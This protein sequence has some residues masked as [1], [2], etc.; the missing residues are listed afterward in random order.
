MFG[1]ISTNEFLRLLNSTAPTPGGGAVVAIN[2]AHAAGLISMVS[3][4]TTK[5]NLSTQSDTVNRDL[6]KC[7]LVAVMHQ[8]KLMKAADADAA[9]FNSLMDCYKLP[10]NTDEE[11]AARSAA[12]I[13]GLKNA[14]EP[15]KQTILSCMALVDFAKIS[16]EQGDKSVV[17]DAFIACRLLATAIRCSVYNLEINMR[18]LSGKDDA[19]VEKTHAFIEK[20]RAAATDLERFIDEKCRF[21]A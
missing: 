7:M 4:I 10:K 19:F 12:L 9:A 14:C 11:K 1:D 21:D 17:S 16:V 13:D 15:P 2:A 20:A 3:N 5:K 18:S 6:V 8:E